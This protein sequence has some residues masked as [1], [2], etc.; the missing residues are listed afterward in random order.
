MQQKKNPCDSLTPSGDIYEQRNPI[1]WLVESRSRY[2]SKTRIRYGICT[3]KE[4]YQFL[5]KYVSS[6]IQ[7][8]NF[9]KENKNP[10][11]G[12]ILSIF[13]SFYPKGVFAKKSD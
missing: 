13:C 2:K 1:I 8:Q 11:F 5:F 12:S 7:W 3:V 4:Q 10:I 9:S 6:K